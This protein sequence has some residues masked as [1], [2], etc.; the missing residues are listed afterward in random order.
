MKLNNAAVAA[1]VVGLLCALCQPAGAIT[2]IDLVGDKDGF[3]LPGAPAVPADGTRWRDDLGGVFFTDYRDAGDLANA[4]FTD[5]W[6]SPASFSYT[7]SYALGGLT[8]LSAVLDIQIA[9]IHD[10]NQGTPYPV[11]VDSVP[12]G[13]IPPNVNPDNFQE[14]RM[15]S[16]NVPLILIAG[17]E[18][19]EVSAGG[20]DGFSVN[21][22]ELRIE[23]VPEPAAAG[24]VA[25]G[26]L[27]LLGFGRRLLG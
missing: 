7:H 11:E 4:P 25:V 21:F 26:M 12:I 22:S 13:V 2:L 10:I 14:V 15:Y 6:D 20:G 9:G 27:T 5:I 1:V 24:F 8:P 3:G 18:S 23:A 16:F 19:I 17:N